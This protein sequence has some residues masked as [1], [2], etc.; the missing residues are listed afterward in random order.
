MTSYKVKNSKYNWTYKYYNSRYKAAP[1]LYTTSYYSKTENTFD[2]KTNT[3]YVTKTYFLKNKKDEKII[4]TEK[5]IARCDLDT[6]KNKLGPDKCD[7][8]MGSAL[9]ACDETLIGKNHKDYRGCQF[10]TKSGKTC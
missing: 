4:C 3:P 9:S 5:L 10:K 2:K 1:T 6:S 8:K 7:E